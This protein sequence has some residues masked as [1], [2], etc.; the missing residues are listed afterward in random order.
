MATNTIRLM[1]PNLQCRKVLAVPIGARGKTVRCRNC[2]MRVKVPP[3][4]ASPSKDSVAV[5]D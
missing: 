2:S 4:P 5:A 1:C 3:Q